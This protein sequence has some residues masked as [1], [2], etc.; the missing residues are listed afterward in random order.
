MIAPNRLFY[1]ALLVS[2]PHSLARKDGCARGHLKEMKKIQLL[3]GVNI[4][5]RFGSKWNFKERYS[6]K[7]TAYRVNVIKEKLI[8]CR[9]RW[10][11]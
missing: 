10:Q 4:T 1:L 2:Q 7:R 6:V 3:Q 5:R 11:S 8:Q 9:G